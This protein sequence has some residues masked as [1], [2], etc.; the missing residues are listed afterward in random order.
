VSDTA[1]TEEVVTEGIGRR[2]R[3]FA[4]GSF[5]ALVLVIPR[6]LRVRRS[7]RAWLAFRVL[8]ATAGAALVILPLSFG[9]NLFPAIAGLAMFLAA[10]LLPSAEPDTSVADK[11]KELGAL[12]VVVG[13]EY[14]PAAGGA[15]AARLFVGAEMIWALDSRLRVILA[16]PTDEINAVTAAESRG[17]W[18]LRVRWR[19]RTADF[20]YRG[21][22][23][24]HFAGVAESTLRGV[25]RP[26]LRVLPQR[27]AAGA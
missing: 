9:N 2:L 1:G 18:I 3:N 20:H 23:A 22:F 25:M 14:Q 24:E 4:I 17:Q 5:F 15:V 10:I 12:V 26:A 8:L 11:A 6:L 7:P 19:E 27:R 13:G 21:V 16:I